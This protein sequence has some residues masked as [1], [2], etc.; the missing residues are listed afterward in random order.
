MKS[1]AGAWVE[2]EIL[3]CHG[4]VSKRERGK[5]AEQNRQRE[6]RIRKKRR[7]INEPGHAHYRSCFRGLSHVP[8]GASLDVR[9]RSQSSGT[10]F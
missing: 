3:G 6:P 1:P 9:H 5:M 10:Q 8:Q 4:S 7:L 2:A